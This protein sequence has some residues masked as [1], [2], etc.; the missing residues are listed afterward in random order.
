MSVLGGK[1]TYCGSVTLAVGIPEPGSSRGRYPNSTA[2]IT[3][4]TGR[5]AK[6]IR[7]ESNDLRSLRL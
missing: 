7:A 2:L 6:L 1:R 4:V 3:K 5:H